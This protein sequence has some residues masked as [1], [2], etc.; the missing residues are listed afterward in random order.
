MQLMDLQN[1][2]PE[3]Q[4]HPLRNLK[5]ENFSRSNEDF[6]QH[7]VFVAIK[8][9]RW[10]GHSA[11][12]E[13]LA[14][15]VP[16]V[17]CENTDEQDQRILKVKNSRKFYAHLASLYYGDLSKSMP[18]IGVTGTNGKT[19]VAYMIESLWSKLGQPIGLIGTIDHHF[20]NKV[21]ESSLTSPDAKGLHHRLCDFADAGARGVVME[22]SSHAIEQDRLAAIDWDACVFTNLSQDH[23]DYHL[24]ME[25]YFQAKAKLF[26]QGLK[27]SAK[28]NPIAIL[29]QD[30]T[31][32]QR[33]LKSPD[34]PIRSFGKHGAQLSFQILQQSLDGMSL[35]WTY[36]GKSREI[37]YSL[38]GEHNAYN[39]A[40]AL[41]TAE[42]LQHQPL[43]VA[44]QL[45]TGVRVPGRLERVNNPQ[46]IYVFI[47]YAHTPDALENVLSFLKTVSG[48]GKIF[49]VYGCGGERDKQK[50]PLM[51]SAGEKY[52]DHLILTSD[53][54]RGEEPAKILED[55]QKGLKQP[56]TIIE[57]RSTAI[58]HALSQ[59]KA[60]DIVLI[61][62]KG[63]EQYQEIAG[64]R[65]KFSDKQQVLDYFA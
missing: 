34:L 31:Y 41:L 26:L 23:L 64:K 20:Q 21:W 18:M 4:N 42:V 55:M 48:Q 29:N 60:G 12:G 35:R 9:N 33:L 47:D 61:A 17:V 62:G 65:L 39:L 32:V 8:G 49:S 27:A 37:S 6:N 38:F 56:A 16:L 7:T 5:I 45:S 58:H 57:D 51:A 43:E 63:H 24:T 13:A 22:A 40:A 1:D 30:D 59:A 44:E 10:D 52:A 3:I 19:T 50:R 54:P 15:K 14:N 53:N 25:N 11:I 36:E 28:K 2:F 46:G